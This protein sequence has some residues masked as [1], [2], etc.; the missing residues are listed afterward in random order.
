M[1]A[2]PLLATVWTIHAAAS[3]GAGC[4]LPV[5]L[6]TASRAGFGD[7]TGSQIL[8]DS[9]AAADKVHDFQLVAALEC[10]AIP[11]GARH[12]FKVQLHGHTV[13]LHTELG[14]QRSYGQPV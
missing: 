4:A 3:C 13:R 10:G 5:L 11:G 14:D 9:T 12:D 2:R 8:A 7:C 6:R 1:T